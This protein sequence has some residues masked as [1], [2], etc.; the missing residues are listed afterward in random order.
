MRF[1]NGESM[2]A[3]APCAR[4][5]V[6]GASSGPS[7][8]KEMSGS[9]EPSRGPRV[10]ILLRRPPAGEHHRDRLE[11]DLE[12]EHR[13]PGVDVL[14]VQLDPAVEVDLVAPADLPQAGQPRLH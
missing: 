6:A 11:Q 1:R 14:Q 8:R 4:T 7:K 3:P 12:V 9:K 5:T 10:A 2:G 13:G